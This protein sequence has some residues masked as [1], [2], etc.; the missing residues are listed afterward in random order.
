MVDPLSE[1][2][3]LIIA[4]GPLTGAPMPTSGRYMVITKSPFNRNY[5][6]I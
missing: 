5:S 4:T 3:K 2:N 1:E 6:N